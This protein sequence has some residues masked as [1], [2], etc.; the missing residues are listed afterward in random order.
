MAE[1]TT[2]TA[3]LVVVVAAGHDRVVSV[4]DQRA[5]A[6]RHDGDGSEAVRR[7]SRRVERTQ[8]RTAAVD[9]SRLVGLLMRVHGTMREVMRT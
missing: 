8:L 9:A 5:R 2:T 3:V 4:D 7:P 6:G 1:V